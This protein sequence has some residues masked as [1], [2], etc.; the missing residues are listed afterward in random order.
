MGIGFKGSPLNPLQQVGVG[1]PQSYQ[2]LTQ[3][4]FQLLCMDLYQHFTL[5]SIYFQFDFKV[6]EDLVLWHKSTSVYLLGLF[7]FSPYHSPS[8][9]TLCLCVKTAN[10]DS[11]Q[12]WQSPLDQVCQPQ[13]GH[14]LCPG[15]KTSER[16]DSQLEKSQVC[17]GGP[18]VR[19]RSS[20]FRVPPAFVFFSCF[21]SNSFYF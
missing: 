5:N 7:R 2:L 6:F 19:G 13:A 15:F 21:N 18:E 10:S 16:N 4:R 20:R 9:P 11:E 12:R 3:R 14:R 1:H 8:I 17:E